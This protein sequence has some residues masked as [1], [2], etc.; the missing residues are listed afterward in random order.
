MIRKILFGGVVLIA[1]AAPA[2]AQD[3]CAAPAAPAIPG[4]DRA[5]TAQ[6]IAAQNNIKAYAAASDK[7]QACLVREIARQKDLAKQ[8]N[9]EFDP[10]IQT[11][12]ES[13]AAAQRK[14]VE[15]VAAAWGTTVQ[16]FNSAQLRKQPL[17]A[18][19]AQRSMGGMGT[20]MGGMSMG[21]GY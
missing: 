18:L 2:M 17:P 8:T 12:L 11:A 6:I 1:L 5:T 19:P 21:S 13:K 9:L 14:D 20:G 16:A 10:S 7:Y 4:G 3:Q 15:R